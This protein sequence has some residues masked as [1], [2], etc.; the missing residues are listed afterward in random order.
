MVAGPG[1]VLT[2]APAAV[3]VGPAPS[4]ASSDV[5]ASA[6]PSAD[7]TNALGAVTLG[8]LPPASDPMAPPSAALIAS[9]T[10]V[11]D[12]P[13]ILTGADAVRVLSAAVDMPSDA[14]RK[15]SLLLA[16]IDSASP[17]A[18]AIPAIPVLPALPPVII[19]QFTGNFSGN[20]SFGGPNSFA[21]GGTLT[22]SGDFSQAANM[23]G[24]ASITSGG[25]GSLAL[26][27][28]SASQASFANASSLSQG[29]THHGWPQHRQRDVHDLAGRAHGDHGY[30]QLEHGPEQLRQRLW[31]LQSCQMIQR[32]LPCPG[33][34]E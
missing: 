2:S 25:A 21:A 29:A 31:Q 20:A 34:S 12:A 11:L 26:S 24:Q 14:V 17:A 33:L 16:A 1:S 23:T 10:R 19:G 15:D 27:G 4:P 32:T 22:I 6:V 5:L 30:R 18:P 13:A 28:F 3:V 8:V 7:F 9:L